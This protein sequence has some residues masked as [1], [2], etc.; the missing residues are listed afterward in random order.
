MLIDGYYSS[1]D[2]FCSRAAETLMLTEVLDAFCRM[3]GQHRE[4]L[5][6]DAHSVAYHKLTRIHDI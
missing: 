4:E 1:S 5:Q 2:R 6:I 3:F